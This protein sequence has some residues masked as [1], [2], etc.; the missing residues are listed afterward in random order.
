M[1][2]IK[3]LSICILTFGLGAE[4]N[5]L[6]EQD[7]LSAPIKHWFS[8]GRLEIALMLLKIVDWDVKHL[9]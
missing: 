4:K 2:E 6:I 7:T 9:V 1:E 8:P 5:H 3:N